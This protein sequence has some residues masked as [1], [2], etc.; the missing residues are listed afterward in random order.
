MD[1]FPKPV[2]SKDTLSTFQSETRQKCGGR[3]FKKTIKEKKEK[4]KE[5]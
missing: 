4:K 5:A 3:R 2:F 1:S